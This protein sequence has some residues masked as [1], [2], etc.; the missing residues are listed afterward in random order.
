MPGT[1][2]FVVA[3]F[4]SSAALMKNI[5]THC[6]KRQDDGEDH[7]ASILFN[8]NH[9]KPGIQRHQ[10]SKG[11]HPQC[12]S[13]SSSASISLGLEPSRWIPRHNKTTLCLE[14]QVS[15]NRDSS[16]SASWRVLFICLCQNSCRSTTWPLD[17][18]THISE[19][20]KYSKILNETQVTTPETACDEGWH[21][22][23]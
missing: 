13:S 18:R 16:N 5:Q 19:G 10:F 11:Q 9:P 21:L 8:Q 7:I 17:L 14:A 15:C 1:L 3:M 23:T 4:G 2:L 6:T 20:Q 12:S 22:N